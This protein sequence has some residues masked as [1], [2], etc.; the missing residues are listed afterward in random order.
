MQCERKLKKKPKRVL[1]FSDG[2]LEEYS[3]EDEVDTPK[4]N[5]TVSQID[6]VIMQIIIKI[7]HIH[8]HTYIIILNNNIIYIL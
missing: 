6:T 1:Q 3:S 2:V 8:T 5:K 7:T 4:Y